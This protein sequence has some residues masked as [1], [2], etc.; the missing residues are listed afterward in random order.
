ML[1]QQRVEHLVLGRPRPAPVLARPAGMPRQQWK[2]ERKRLMA[3]G[4]RLAPGIEEAVQ[5][6]ER[7]SGPG[8]PETHE[9]IA[10]QREG[11]LRRLYLSGA[12]D[13][14]QLNS[15]VEIAAVSERIGADVG[16]RTASL[17]TRIDNPGWRAEP[18]FV[19]GL[20]RVRHE[21][22]YTRWRWLVSRMG[23]LNAVL[24]MIVGEPIGFTVAAKRY[25][26]HN[27]RAKRLLID[28]LDLWPD[29]LDQVW[30]SLDRDTIN[31]A[32]KRLGVK[33]L[34]TA[35]VAT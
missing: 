32:H 20:T 35:E 22:A 14:E 13:A 25:G 12:I 23:P 18:V 28:A 1:E 15:A 34:E 4:Q 6:R 24:D 33:I 10:Q 8:T 5:R 30:Q 29:I 31:Q 27:R 7:F 19:E 16:I 9:R 17:E 11:A 21:V 26:M 3:E 2:H